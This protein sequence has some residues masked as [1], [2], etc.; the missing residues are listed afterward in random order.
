[1][2]AIVG[3]IDNHI[4]LYKCLGVDYY[5]QFWDYSIPSKKHYS[6]YFE[7]PF[8][9]AQLINAVILSYRVNYSLII[10]N[11]NKWLNKNYKGQKNLKYFVKSYLRRII[12]NKCSAVIVVSPSLKSYLLSNDLN[13]EIVWIPFDC[14]IHE[15]VIKTKDH[16]VISIPGS[17]SNLKKYDRILQV[18]KNLNNTNPKSFDV[19]L[20]G[21]PIDEYGKKWM[22]NFKNLKLKNIQ[23]TTFENRISDIEFH[24]ILKK[25]DIILSD[26]N[27]KILTYD[28][29]LE[30]YGLTK[31]TGV[32]WLAKKYNCLAVLPGHYKTNH[33]GIKTLTIEEVLRDSNK[34][35][36][37]D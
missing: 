3:P 28:F 5:L 2:K 15:K 11:S 27:K 21:A 26:F 16:L 25:S 4:S 12:L 10:H 6:F 37:N 14:V 31:E 32:G 23:I 8:S 34:L 18:L 36:N 30:E 20:L 1:M 9:I 19:I 7:E 33:L 22:E 29:Y 17:M 13:K 35:T 24:T